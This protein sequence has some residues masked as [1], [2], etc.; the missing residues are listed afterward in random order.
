MYLTKKTEAVLVRGQSG[1]SGD[2][3]G[4]DRALGDKWDGWGENVQHVKFYHFFV[5][6]EEK[7]LLLSPRRENTDLWRGQE[8]DEE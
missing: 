1:G 3:V 7:R 4:N 6:A 8:D 5:K 2:K